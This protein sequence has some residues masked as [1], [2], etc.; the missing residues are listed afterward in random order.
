MFGGEG[1]LITVNAINAA[2]QKTGGRGGS[3]MKRMLLAAAT[4]SMLAL[5]APSMASASAH[6]GK[7]HGR[8]HHACAHAHHARV[9][10]FGAP[11][12]S[13]GTTPSGTTPTAPSGD[14]AGTV[15][16][17]TG[18]VLTITLNDKS[19]V[20]GKVTD[21]TE[22]ACE[23]AAPTE[24]SETDDNGDRNGDENSGGNGDDT[25]HSGQGVGSMGD[26]MSSGHDG[27]DAGQTPSTCTSAALV[28][29]AVVREA[30]L[31]IGSTGSVWKHV[32]LVQ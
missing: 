4:S 17:F 3:D 18:G 14:T 10:N 21:Q 8:S 29:G 5:A 20:S 9:I 23:S 24:G 16:S 11:L 15:A 26:D 25:A 1:C 27:E 7:C 6:H 13:S 31:S 22:L 19:T 30:E 12:S 2:A 28:P 32:D